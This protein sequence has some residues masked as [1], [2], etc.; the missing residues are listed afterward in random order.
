M[1]PREHK[2][3]NLLFH[4]RVA[5]I[6]DAEGCD[7]CMKLRRTLRHVYKKVEPY[8]DE[9]VGYIWSMDAITWSNHSKQ[10]NR[11]CIVMRDMGLS[12]FLI[13]IHLAH[14]SDATESIRRVVTQMRND[15][16]F[17]EA[18]TTFGFRLI[19]EIRTDPAGE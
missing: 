7:V 11:Y 12:G 17:D 18:Q 3:T 1:P 13:L 8:K 15:P 10:G 19:S 9:R 6:G 5:H 16:R 14:K 4:K 2:L